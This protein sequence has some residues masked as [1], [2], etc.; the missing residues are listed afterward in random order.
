M[1]FVWLIYMATAS[2]V[3]SCFRSVFGLVIQNAENLSSRAQPKGLP[4]CWLEGIR[5][6]NVPYP[7]DKITLPLA[8]RSEIEAKAA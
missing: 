3:T 4:T 8:R 6:D 5:D 7:I 1:Q 2:M